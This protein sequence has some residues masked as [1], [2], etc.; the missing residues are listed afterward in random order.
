MRFVKVNGKPHYLLRAVDHEGGVLEFFVNKTR[1]KAGALKFLK[2]ALKRYG[3]PEVIVTDELGSFSAAM[4]EIGNLK[5]REV[6]Q[7]K[8]NR[9][10][11]FH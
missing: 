6:G 5:R 9:V 4:G 1:G 2:K 10:E 11:N 8:N 3:R 7:W